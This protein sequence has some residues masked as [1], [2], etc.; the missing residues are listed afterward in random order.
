MTLSVQDMP[1][2]AFARWL[3]EE[4]GLSVVVAEDVEDR[5]VSVDVEEVDVSQVLQVTARRHGVSIVQTG[6]VVFVGDLRPDDRGVLVASVPRLGAS[7]LRE[8]VRVLQSEHGRVWSDDSGLVVVGDR[9]ETLAR[10]QSMLEQVEQSGVGRWL[11]QLHVVNVSRSAERELGLDA[12]PILDAAALAAFEGTGA[13]FELDGSAGLRAMLRLAHEREDMS[14]ALE[15]LFLLADGVEGRQADSRRVPIPQR[16][17]SDGVVETVGFEYVEAGTTVEV[18]VRRLDGDEAMLSVDL[19]LTMLDG[20]VSDAP[21]TAG[22]RFSG[23]APVDVGGTFLVGS[24]DVHEHQDGAG[25]SL[26]SVAVEAKRAGSFQVWARVV[27]VGA[28]ADE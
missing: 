13:D 12:E 1:L 9:V 11:V 23:E 18:E 16:A 27:H 8:A 17:V 4:T 15:P 24:F 2:I 26:G 20:F 21:I 7:E 10:I 25:G 28:L 22:Q 6:A 14:V 3:S 19:E 5:L